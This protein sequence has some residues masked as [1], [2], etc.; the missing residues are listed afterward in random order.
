M[1]I[2]VCEDICIEALK[3]QSK[4]HE[5]ALSSICELV[6]GCG[7]GHHYVHVSKFK[8]FQ[9]NLFTTKLF[10]AKYI[11]NIEACS[12]LSD[13]E[14]LTQKLGWI[15]VV[16][17]NKDSNSL[18][19]FLKQKEII[20]VN[21]SEDTSLE[22]YEE[23]HLIAE[24][25]KD[26]IIFQAIAKN[27]LRH[28]IGNRKVDICVMSRNGGGKTIE[29]VVEFETKDNPNHFCLIITDS[30]KN[31]PEDS[32]IGETAQAVDTVMRQNDCRFAHFYHM[33][34]V[35]ELEN[36][37]PHKLLISVLSHPNPQLKEVAK[38]NLS[39]YDIK[40]GL[41]VSMLQVEKAFTY[42][43][44]DLDNKVSVTIKSYNE[45]IADGMRPSDSILSGWGGNFI[46]HF[47]N[48]KNYKK[49]LKALSEISH[50]QLTEDQKH[51]WIEIS[52][53]IINWGLCKKR[54][55]L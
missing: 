35:R 4:L 9:R 41:K 3:D 21:P 46:S 2:Y 36:L 54:A 25:L 47:I 55:Q 53:R 42:Y 43:Q 45:F 26:T 34:R 38:G 6:H 24:N 33:T 15:A 31:Y 1:L 28:I 19:E 44:G 18:P 52:R 40:D 30:D 14:P 17:F 51:E 8:T 48:L 32:K 13:F 29:N 37:I 12:N 49:N 16:S 50:T 11:A 22:L 20:F 5:C 27:C 39:F 23:S 7:R 10:P